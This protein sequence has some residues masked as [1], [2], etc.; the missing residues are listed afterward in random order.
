MPTFG[1]HETAQRLFLSGVG[2]IYVLKSDDKKVIKVLQPPVGIWSEERIQEEIDAFRLRAKSQKAAAQSS[3]NWA[4]IHEIAALRDSP[5][6][7]EASQAASESGETSLPSHVATGA[8]LVMDRYER[9][10][11]S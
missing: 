3:K 8:Y 4:P 11:Q 7:A 9:S 6:Y 5:A 2:G 1:Q 10:A